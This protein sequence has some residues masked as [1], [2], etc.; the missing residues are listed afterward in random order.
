MVNAIAFNPGIIIRV[1]RKDEI[2][3]AAR[4]NIIDGYIA[5]PVGSERNG[6]IFSLIIGVIIG[7]DFDVKV[8][9]NPDVL[10]VIRVPV[11]G[12]YPRPGRKRRQ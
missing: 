3:P 10:G 1:E 9:V 8:A 6:D 11:I 7:P 4:I 5:I 12:H 2:N